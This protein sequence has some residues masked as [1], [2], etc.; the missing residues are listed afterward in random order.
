MFVDGIVC[1]SFSE[2]PEFMGRSKKK[3]P[4]ARQRRSARSRAVSWLFRPRRLV[5]LAGLAV[6]AVLWP[7]MRRQ[8]PDLKSQ[9]QYQITLDRITVTPAPRWIPDNLTEDVLRR[10]GIRLPLSLHDPALSER[11][12][13]AFVTHPW[14]RTVHRVSRSWPAG[15]RVD[16]TYRRPVAM[17]RGVDGFYPIDTEGCLL[18]GSDFRQSDVNRY[19]VVENITTVPAA[20]QGQPWGDPAVSGAARLAER[21]LE[22]QE[23]GRSYWE[24]WGLAA[25]EVSAQVGLPE[26]LSDAQYA[27]RTS[28][29]SRIIWGRAPDTRHPGEVSAD[30][31]LQRMAEYHRIYG[32]FDDA[33]E[34]YV[35]DLREWKGIRR[36]L[37]RDA[38]PDGH[39]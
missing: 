30:Q 19:P 35:F 39:R 21:L 9:P 2:F 37:A 29:G 12:A 34:A 11:I 20:G 6:A 4:S 24:I 18:P 25:I 22:T 28:G 16:V 38:R 7:Q 23:D 3:K 26:E 10:V 8:L 15:I 14:I 13:A 1:S 32:S 17:V 33:P 36:S 31:K 5:L 27:L